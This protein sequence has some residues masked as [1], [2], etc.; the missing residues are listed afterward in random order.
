MAVTSK[1]GLFLAKPKYQVYSPNGPSHR[2][3]FGRMN[4]SMAISAR[5]GTMR[6]W[7]SQGASSSGSSISPPMTLISFPPRGSRDWLPISVAGWWPR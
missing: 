6:S 5:A 2:R 1:T 4:P 3:S 7:V